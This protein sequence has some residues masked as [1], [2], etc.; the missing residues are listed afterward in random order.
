MKVRGKPELLNDV[1]DEFG[2]K[3]SMENVVASIWANPEYAASLPEVQRKVIEGLDIEK[4]WYA[5][6][7]GVEGFRQSLLDSIGGDG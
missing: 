5:T 4:C 3:I 1:L 6:N 7:I 2:R